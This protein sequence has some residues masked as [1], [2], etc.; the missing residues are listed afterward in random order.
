MILHLCQYFVCEELAYCFGSNGVEGIVY[1][2]AN[3]KLAFAHAKCAA[4]LYF[5]AK[6][7]FGNQTLQL[8]Y[9][10]TR[11]FDVAGATDTNCN[12]KHFVL[13]HNI[14]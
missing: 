12:F 1:R 6:V 2:Y 11:A 7:V 4:E 3:A 5:V 8:L 9:Y 10:L 13:P 14:L